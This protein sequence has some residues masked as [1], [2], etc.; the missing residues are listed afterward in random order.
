MHV[1]HYLAIRQRGRVVFERI[2]NEGEPE[3]T[4]RS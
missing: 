4:F 1:S 3:L 2:V